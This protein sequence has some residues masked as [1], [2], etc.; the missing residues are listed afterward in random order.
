MFDE[1]KHRHK[2]IYMFSAGD[3]NEFNWYYCPDCMGQAVANL[4][5]VT[6]LVSLQVFEAKK[7]DKKKKK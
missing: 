1:F 4:D 2:W 5:S 6:G 7:P 3:G